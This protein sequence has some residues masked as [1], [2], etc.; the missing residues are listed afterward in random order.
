MSA[1]SMGYVTQDLL[2]SNL[3]QQKDGQIKEGAAG[4]I[5]NKTAK[6]EAATHTVDVQATSKPSEEPEVEKK[7]TPVDKDKDEASEAKKTTPKDHDAQI[8][9]A[10]PLDTNDESV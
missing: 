3:D 2:K 10:Q 1:M 4:P 8:I 7:S 5:G 6:N 9:D